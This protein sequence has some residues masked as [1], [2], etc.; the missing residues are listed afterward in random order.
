MVDHP[1]IVS[2][3]PYFVLPA[4]KADLGGNGNLR[5]NFRLFS[6]ILGKLR[7]FLEKLI[8]NEV[9]LGGSP[10]IKV[11]LSQYSWNYNPGIAGKDRKDEVL[12][13]L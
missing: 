9:S 6:E 11:T 1:L 5:G 10:T 2:L 12:C 13:V 7:K 3:H 4:R 8:Q